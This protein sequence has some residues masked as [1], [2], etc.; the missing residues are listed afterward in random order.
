MAALP[1][2][3]ALYGA[4]DPATAEFDS[5]AVAD[6]AARYLPITARSP[7]WFNN[8]MDVFGSRT[9][10]AIPDPESALADIVEPATPDDVL[11]V[12]ELSRLVYVIGALCHTPRFERMALQPESLLGRAL[13][14]AGPDY[15]GQ[16]E[17]AVATGDSLLQLL[18]VE[19]G[20]ARDRD[21]VFRMAFAQGLLSRDVA[22]VPQ[23]IPS[24]QTVD[25]YECVVIDTISRR[26]D[27][28]L[29]NLKDVVDPLNWHRNYPHAF[30]RMDAQN[31][32]K[33]P[34]DWSR[35]LET[36]SLDCLGG[37]PRM[38]TPLEYYKSDPAP[39]QAVLQYDLDKSGL[40]T[41]GDGRVKVD[42]GFIKMWATGNPGVRVRTRK[43]VHIDG[44]WPAAQAM[45]V[46]PSGYASMADEMIFGNAT[47]PPADTVPWQPSPASA[48]TTSS[49]PTGP[50][51]GPQKPSSG[52]SVASTT[53]QTWIDCLKDLA[54]KNLQLSAKWWKNQLTVDDLVTYTQDVGAEIASA[55]WRLI[56]ALSQPPD[57]GTP[58]G[59]A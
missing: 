29:Q 38:V 40:A 56:Q 42:R 45:F 18:F 33:L 47:N 6:A 13:A 2:L 54:D 46:C 8:I 14:L 16:T 11:T 15:E 31:P 9:A 59:D 21:R 32:D 48:A 24:T 41:L 23:C 20:S 37:W 26:S 10:E 43:I 30:C 7:G 50:S 58:G 22:E 39:D 49:T 4:L 12:P 19:L 1:S 5:R 53:A 3:M 34:S 27:I 25:G 28:Y 44:L 35:V 51:N 17:T 52:G 36:V 55:P 57:D